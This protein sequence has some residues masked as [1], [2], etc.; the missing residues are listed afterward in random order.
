MVKPFDIPKYGITMLGTSNGFDPKG[1][2]TSFIIWSNCKGCL[3]D[4]PPDSFE[5]LRCMGIPSHLIESMVLTHCHADNDAGAFQNILCYGKLTLITTRTIKDSFLRKYAAITGF[6]N[7]YLNGL[8]SFVPAVIGQPATFHESE[9]KFFYSLHTIPTVGFELFFGDTSKS[10]IYSGDTSFNR[11]L[12]KDLETRMV[13][14]KK[15]AANLLNFPFKNTHDLVFH[16]LGFPPIHTYED[17]LIKEI[18][19]TNEKK[20][21]STV[22]PV[23]T[24]ANSETVAETERDYKAL[25]LPELSTLC[26]ENCAH[27]MQGV[28]ESTLWLQLLALKKNESHREQIC[29]RLAEH[30]K[31]RMIKSG[32]QYTKRG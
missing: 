27:A 24:N 6:D 32:R 1:R 9:I 23:G 10:M 25:F 19:K 20:Y 5:M 26:I 30:S 2:T 17:C 15:R 29:E 7:D 18:P 31:L 4:P 14:G 21:K 28:V 22:I 11:N 8:F 16:D 12:V 13:I 3:V